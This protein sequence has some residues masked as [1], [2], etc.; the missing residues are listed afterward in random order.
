MISRR[1][2]VL[3]L[4]LL[5]LAACNLTPTQITSD[6]NLI[7]N[8]LQTELPIL[9]AISGLSPAQ[10]A[11]ISG[12][13]AQTV[14]AAQALSSSFTPNGNFPQTFVSAVNDL[15]VFMQ[16]PAISSLLP[17]AAAQ[18]ILAVGALLPVVEASFGLTAGAKRLPPVMSPSTARLIL[19]KVS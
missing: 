14:A 10:Q 12:D 3:A 18:V 9:L 16:S 8:S 11:Q 15:V 17:P 6:V 1:N 7:G 4:G 5:P 19:S 13:V 2:A